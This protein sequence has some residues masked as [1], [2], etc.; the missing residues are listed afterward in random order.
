VIGEDTTPLPRDSYASARLA[1]E[2]AI[3]AQA[4]DCKVTVLRLTNAVGPPAR[5]SV[6]RW[7]LVANDLCLQAARGGD[8]SLRSTGLQWRDFVPMSDVSHVILGAAEGRI[9]PGTFNLGS[10]HPMTVLQLA[11]LVATAAV[12]LGMSRPAV[13]PGS[14]GPVEQSPPFRISVERL[15]REGFTPRGDLAREVQDTIAFCRRQSGL[16]GGAV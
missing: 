1:S 2:H 10:G 4:G 15:A 16:I 11:D 3:G 8:L 14:E 6:D 12:G 7:T 9:R 13:I 5:S